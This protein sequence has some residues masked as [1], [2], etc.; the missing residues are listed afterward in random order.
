[1]TITILVPVYGVERYIEQCACSLFKQTYQD[2][3][4]VFCDDCTPD[5]SI[6]VLRSVVARYPD[7]APHV[8]I[9]RNDRNLGLGGTRAQL[10]EQVKTEAFT[11]VDSD[12][13]LPPNALAD[14]A[15]A[16]QQTGADIVTGRHDT[17]LSE[18][19][20]VM[21]FAD[22]RNAEE[23]S[24]GARPDSQ[25]QSPA[26]RTAEKAPTP[27]PSLNFNKVLCQNLVPNRVWGRLYRTEAARRVPRL[28]QQGIDYAEDQCAIARLVAV[29]SFADT[30]AVVYHYRT[31]NTASY[32]NNISMRAM[33]SYFRSQNEVLAFYRRRGHLPLALEVGIL[34]T[35]R[36][37]HRHGIPL[38][39]ADKLLHYYPEHR[40]ALV[41]YHLL[42]RRTPGADTL[43]KLL[44]LWAAH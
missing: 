2:I 24:T 19:L 34:N 9:I 38:A 11:I 23:W 27:H 5:R 7:R 14:L 20:E 17:S 3:R 41:L 28:F 43:Y 15:T 1:M 32:T 12:D 10:L 16:M 21:A 26:F 35:Y 42:R 33:Q 37:C 13:A 40:A 29:C 30:P 36:E 39:E 4:Y 8:S 31:D 25:D 18:K 44:R 6:D 22:V